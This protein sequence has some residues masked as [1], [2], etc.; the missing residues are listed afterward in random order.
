M[1][2]RIFLSCGQNKSSEEPQIAK[3][4]AQ[5]LT[6]THGFDCYIAV[7]EQSLLGL[8]ENIF[9]QLEN[10]DYFLFIDFKRE[11][12]GEETGAP[13]HRGSLFS[14]QELA[15]ASFL[16]IP[17]LV[18]HE[19]GVKERDGIVGIVQGNSVQFSDRSQLANTIS[20][21]IAE[22]LKKG[23]WSNT[24]RNVLTLEAIPTPVVATVYPVGNVSHFFHI[25]VR[26]NHHRKTA[27]GIFAYLESITNLQ[28]QKLQRPETIELKWAGTPL[29]AVPIGPETSRKFDALC[30]PHVVPLKPFFATVSDSTQFSITIDTPGRYRLTYSLVSQ[31]FPVATKNFV[32]EFA[33]DLAKV[34]LTAEP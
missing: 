1:R 31:N 18:L 2:A 26:N 32:L 7:R 20:G 16:N 21:M 28:T 22:K 5:K 33:N 13:V 10:S 23:E 17:A 9:R 12:I 24:S 29:P 19:K 8:R 25:S 34:T 4:V 30:I 14:H 6:D 15:I 3:D 11:A 27:L